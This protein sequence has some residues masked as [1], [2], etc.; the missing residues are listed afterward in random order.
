V[1]KETVEDFNAKFRSRVPV[2][3]KDAC[4]EWA[5]RRDRN[6]YGN[7]WRHGISKL[8]HRIAYEFAFGVKPEK[9]FVV[10]HKCDNPSCCNPNHLVLGTQAE[11]NKDRAAKGR[12]KTRMLPG[13][14]HP[15]AK[16]TEDAVRDIRTGGPAKIHMDRYGVSESLVFQIRSRTIWTHVK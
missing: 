3:D 8:A 2:G 16:I 4:W 9:G 13:E 10:M 5:G 7:I 12:T 15:S 6:G 11:N 14:A 1:R